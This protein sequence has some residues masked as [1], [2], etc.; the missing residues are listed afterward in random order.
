MIYKGRNRDTAWFGMTDGDWPRVK[1][2]FERFL[3][4][5]NFDAGKQRRK[6]EIAPAANL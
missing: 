4:P 3:K 5:E 1:A 2:G 6:L